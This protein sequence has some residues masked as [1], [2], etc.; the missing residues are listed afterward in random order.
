MWTE[1][2]LWK[3]AD[4][5]PEL[6]SPRRQKPATL[7]PILS[8]RPLFLPRKKPQ[9]RRK[10]RPPTLEELH[11]EETH[12]SIY[13]SSK[14]WRRSPN[15]TMD[16]DYESIAYAGGNAVQQE[17]Y[18]NGFW[19]MFLNKSTVYVLLL[20]VVNVL[21]L[22]AVSITLDQAGRK[23]SDATLR[24]SYYF[25]QLDIFVWGTLSVICISALLVFRFCQPLLRRTVCEGDGSVYQTWRSLGH[26]V[27]LVR[28]LLLLSR[29][30][31]SSMA[32]TNGKCLVLGTNAEGYDDTTFQ[33]TTLLI[34]I[35]SCETVVFSTIS[36]PLPWTA[37]FCVV[38]LF[39]QMVRYYS[40]VDPLFV[41]DPYS[42]YVSLC[43]WLALLTTY[44]IVGLNTSVILLSARN[45]YQNTLH[46]KASTARKRRFVDLLCTEIRSPLHHLVGS[47]SRIA[48]TVQSQSYKDDIISV[49]QLVTRHTQFVNL[50]TDNLLFLTRV[51]EGRALQATSGGRGVVNPGQ[52]VRR[53][54]DVK[55]IVQK[56][57]AQYTVLDENDRVIADLSEMIIVTDRC[58]GEVLAD[59]TLLSILVRD[60]LFFG[61]IIL[62]DKRNTEALMK[63]LLQEHSRGVVPPLARSGSKD[64][65]LSDE[66]DERRP[67][68]I[69]V[70][71]ESDD[72]HHTARGPRVGRSPA[73]PTACLLRLQL[74]CPVLEALVTKLEEL[75]E[76][77]IG[78]RPE[79]LDDAWADGPDALADED[80]YSTIL[81]TCGA[82]SSKA[83]GAFKI[84]RTDINL[85]LACGG[86]AA[87][88][89]PP[90]PTPPSP[91]PSS[92]AFHASYNNGG[93]DDN[94]NDD[95][96]EAPLLPPGID[97]VSLVVDVKSIRAGIITE[98]NEL[99][100]SIPALLEMAGLVLENVAVLCDFKSSDQESVNELGRIYDLCVVTSAYECGR[101][102]ERGYGGPVVLFSGSMAYL[103]D[104]NVNRC[105]FVVPMPFVKTDVEDF[106]TWLKSPVHKVALGPPPRRVA[107]DV[108]SVASS[109]PKLPALSWLLGLPGQLPY[110]DVI[111]AWFAARSYTRSLAS[112]ALEAMGTRIRRLAAGVADLFT[113]KV[114]VDAT[115]ALG[116]KF[117]FL[118]TKI[119]F[120]PMFTYEIEKAFC[121]WRLL[122]P[123]G[124]LLY[125]VAATSHATS[126]MSANFMFGVIAF[127]FLV[128]QKMS[129]D[130]D[131]VCN[132]SY[133]Y[134][135]P[136]SYAVPL[137]CVVIVLRDR[138]YRRVIEPSGICLYVFWFVGSLLM[139]SAFNTHLLDF[140]YYHSKG[141]YVWSPHY[142]QK[143][144]P[145]KDDDDY[146]NG[147]TVTIK[148]LTFIEFCTTSF[149]SSIG[150]E[151]LHVLFSSFGIICAGWLF[152]IMWPLSIIS[153][154]IALIRS[155]FIIYNVF[156]YVE[157]DDVVGDV[158]FLTFAMFA[159]MNIVG[160]FYL[161]ITLRNEFQSFR[162]TT[163]SHTFLALSLD[164][165]QRNLHTPFENIQ[166]SKR[167]FMRILQDIALS[168][169][170]AF[171]SSCLG[172]LDTLHMGHLMLRGLA[173]E[174]EIGDKIMTGD[175]RF[176]K[177]DTSVVLLVEEVMHIAAGFR[178]LRSDSGVKVYVTVDPSLALVR[179]NTQLLTSALMNAL[180][181]THK[182]IWR[183]TRANGYLRSYVPEISIEVTPHG[184]G[185]PKGFMDTRLF[186]IEVRESNGFLVPATGLKPSAP[187]APTP[188]SLAP[189][190]LPE[191]G[192][193]EFEGFG[194][195]V[196]R[197]IVLKA[198]PAAFFESSPAQACGDFFTFSR[199]RFT[200]PYQ[201]VP[202]SL[203]AAAF[204]KAMRF[205]GAILARRSVT[206]YLEAY[207][208][209]HRQ[210]SLRM[211]VDEAQRAAPEPQKAA[212][213]ALSVLIIEPGKA[214]N[215]K[216]LRLLFR[217]S[218]WKVTHIGGV[219]VRGHDA[220]YTCC[221]CCASSRAHTHGQPPSPLPTLPTSRSGKTFT[222]RAT[223][224]SSTP[225]PSRSCC[226]RRPAA[227]PAAPRTSTSSRCCA[228][229][230]TR[231]SSPNWRTKTGS[232]WTTASATT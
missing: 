33:V 181:K 120:V 220:W 160:Q 125:H 77:A 9:P 98:S 11:A 113:T 84:T 24:A 30:T 64:S 101:I 94:D 204:L 2:P 83:G 209:F 48:D 219:Q 195:Q 202:S 178:Y 184:D 97:A 127:Y 74:R 231:W 115:Y 201:F 213:A 68:L 183:R 155:F 133:C 142:W 22:S 93:D 123:T 25:V 168:Q 144:L 69:T 29:V 152:H 164:S 76:A 60:V 89:P 131:R 17:K 166:E 32:K 224:F 191:D 175:E 156:Q 42:T 110:V 171:R 88:S 112:V 85:T 170:V 126:T 23:T 177:R 169:R 59:A 165:M 96:D 196:C 87:P 225:A 218:G 82:L 221:W 53:P 70:S 228:S 95:D 230:R 21:F 121:K 52:T 138:I 10:L 35:D 140:Y 92:A 67:L 199:Q 122:N 62:E 13:A 159:I 139:I 130:D 55:G 161:E 215:T 44:Y 12:W 198:A 214:L 176:Y 37:L 114:E 109:V 158:I 18:E 28:L 145:T 116:T 188:S 118:K 91:P 128:T 197:D 129:T 136:W 226:R 216:N 151:V 78:R 167:R 119:F 105:D 200:L 150:M 146:V 211:K 207:E 227:P 182:A 54:V 27:L 203:T 7:L 39:S 157:M 31:I 16:Y 73:A 187:A 72:K 4:E 108:S 36:F 162:K 163:F 193:F 99:A 107:D 14:L 45:F 190:L 174:L 50:I 217:K 189:S 81:M 179:M 34:L 106:K 154:F 47:V 90:P 57:A 232:D 6:A 65:L 143:N 43:M 135:S 38:E 192:D 46:L 8:Q 132:Q 20:Q 80:D 51:E 223:A 75:R 212:A 102:K 86:L 185:R 63:K 172:D 26:F 180:S 104:E 173:Y 222:C 210:A 194:M 61:R 1:N 103:D 49:G 206:K 229:S 41:Q 117:N 56:L 147:N 5:S 19:A 111:F 134:N 208:N 79:E 100:S 3:R 137:F 71:V 141:T 186:V 149:G 40:C 58:G 148:K 153:T 15:T 66:S 205:P 124:S